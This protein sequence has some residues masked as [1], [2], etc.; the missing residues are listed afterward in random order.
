V[1]TGAAIVVATGAAVYMLVTG[2][3]TLACMGAADT[4]DVDAPAGAT[5][6][7]AEPPDINEADGAAI[8][9]V[10]DAGAAET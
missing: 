8:V 5:D 10:C 2:A 7:D 3:E 9:T 4:I 1:A 6:I